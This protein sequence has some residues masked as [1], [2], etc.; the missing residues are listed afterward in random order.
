MGVG[1]PFPGRVEVT[2]VVG[3][4][5]DSPPTPPNANVYV[6]PEA[7]TCVADGGVPLVELREG[8]IVPVQDVLAPFALV[9]EVKLVAVGD[10]VRLDGGRGGDPVPGPLPR[11]RRRSPRRRGSRERVPC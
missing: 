1:T 5:A 4:G 7:G 2:R 11:G 3:V 9:D 10:H 6:G 8:N